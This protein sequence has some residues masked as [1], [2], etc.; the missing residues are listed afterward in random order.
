MCARS[1]T[2]L[3]RARVLPVPPTVWPVITPQRARTADK[4]TTQQIRQQLHAVLVRLQA[5]YPVMR[6]AS[7]MNA[8]R[9][10]FIT[11]LMARVFLVLILVASASMGACALTVKLG[12]TSIMRPWVMP[13][14]GMVG[15]VS[16]V[17]TPA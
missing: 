3:L 14:L 15:T 13:Q 5:V 6:L 7:A 4:G 12:S 17:I 16:D 1:A 2:T 11:V 10:G 8:P 9:I